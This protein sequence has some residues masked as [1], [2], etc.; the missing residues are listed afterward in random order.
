[1]KRRRRRRRRRKEKCF[2][3]KMIEGLLRMKWGV[4]CTKKNVWVMEAEV[5]LS[6]GCVLDCGKVRRWEGG[7]EL[8]G[9]I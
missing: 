6:S 2:M 7:K 3:V 9:S 8:I 1:M 4:V 5:E